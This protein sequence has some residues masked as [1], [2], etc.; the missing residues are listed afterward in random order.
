MIVTLHT[1]SIVMQFKIILDSGTALNSTDI[2]NIFSNFRH[3][4]SATE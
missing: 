3:K 4:K 1:I 2:G